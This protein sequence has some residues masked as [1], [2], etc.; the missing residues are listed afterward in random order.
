MFGKALLRFF[1]ASTITLT[2]LQGCSAERGATLRV[3]TKNLIG[4][5]NRVAEFTELLK[6]LGYRQR[7]LLNPDTDHYDAVVERYGEHQMLFQG[8]DRDGSGIRV[9]VHIKI[10]DGST[11]IRF[12]EQGKRGLS[13]TAV[14]RFNALKQRVELEFGQQNVT[15]EHLGLMAP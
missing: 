7:F 10:S 12:Y 8:G 1:L 11:G 6:E 2:L 5:E 3:E 15:L 13:Q 14:H 4:F 9:S